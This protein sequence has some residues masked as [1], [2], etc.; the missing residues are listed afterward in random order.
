[1]KLARYE[2]DAMVAWM[3]AEKLTQQAVGKKLHVTHV[4]VM[5]WVNG[6]GIRPLQ[7]ARLRPLIGPYIKMDLST[8]PAAE[9]S[10]LRSKL[11]SHSGTHPDLVQLHLAVLDQLEDF[12]ELQKQ[13]ATPS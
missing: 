7:L 13:D 2:R 4:S 10:A 12:L 1:M 9:L 5:K 3:K 6:G 11:Q 8:Q